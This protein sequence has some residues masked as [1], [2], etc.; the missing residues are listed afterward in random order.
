MRARAV[1]CTALV[2]L[3]LGGCSEEPAGGPATPPIAGPASSAP[4]GT[5]TSSTSP[6]ART[7]GLFHTSP[8]P[9]G[10]TPLCDPSQAYYAQDGH[11]TKVQV[12]LHGP[13]DVSVEVDGK[14]G[15]IKST[16][17]LIPEQ[18][19]GHLFGFPTIPFDTVTGVAVAASGDAGAGSCMAART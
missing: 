7:G 12:I 6:A 1:T 5:L 13:V 10:G 4:A 14:N 15:P 3:L 8:N 2:V 11:G 19:T 16:G 9:K 18:L 17:F